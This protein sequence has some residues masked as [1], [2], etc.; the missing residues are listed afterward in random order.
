VA[1]SSAGMSSGEGSSSSMASVSAIRRVP[2]NDVN[3]TLNGYTGKAMNESRNRE[4]ELVLEKLVELLQKLELED[5]DG[6]MQEIEGIND[7]ESIVEYLVKI[8]ELRL[9]DRFDQVLYILFEYDRQRGNEVAQ[10][11]LNDDEFIRR[12]YACEILSEYGVPDA[13]SS[14]LDTAKNDIDADVRASALL[15]IAKL[16]HSDIL[17]EIEQ[18][19]L[20]DSGITRQGSSI[21]SIA[22]MVIGEIEKK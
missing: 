16:G 5:N 18:I 21:S 17:P 1:H 14:L 13:L 2:S 20:G 9:V 6:I 22:L 12:W 11:L 10:M 4:Q 19:R 3:P 15:A 7:N 8:I